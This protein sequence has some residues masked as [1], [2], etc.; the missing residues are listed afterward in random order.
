MIS[1][2]KARGGRCG[3]DPEL[4]AARQ[5]EDEKIAKEEAEQV[6]PGGVVDFLALRRT[7]FAGWW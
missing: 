4:E 3:S 7:V 5:R 2:L 1:M 6:R